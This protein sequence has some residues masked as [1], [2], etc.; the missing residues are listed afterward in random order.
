MCLTK[1]LPNTGSS[2]APVEEGCSSKGMFPED[3]EEGRKE[4]REGRKTEKERK[5]ERKKEGSGRGGEGGR[6]EGGREG[7]R[8]AEVAGRIGRKEGRQEESKAERRKKD[9][10]ERRKREGK[11]EGE[12]KEEGSGGSE[13]ESARLPC[14]YTVAPPTTSTIVEWYIEEEQGT[15]MRVAFR[16]QGGQAQS[17]VGTP[18]AGRVSIGEDLSLTISPVQP[19]DELTFYCQVTAGPAGLGD[20]PTMLKVFCE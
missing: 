6:G 17:D 8:E 18:L 2:T 20:A 7:W 5:K 12:G 1:H 3:K 10:K 19:S 4:G 15:R 13:G 11:K 16:S 9:K 14:R